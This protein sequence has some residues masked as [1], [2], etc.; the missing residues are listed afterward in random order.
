MAHHLVDSDLE[1]QQV[2]SVIPVLPIRNAVLF[3]MISMPLVVGRPRSILA[4]ESS[5]SS[6]QLL[7]IVAQKIITPGD[8]EPKDLYDIGTLCKLESSTDN[9]VGGRQIVV[10]GVARYR[11]LGYQRTESGFLTAR[12]EIVADITEP[13]STRGTALFE[14]LKSLSREIMDLLPGATEALSRLIDR[15]DDAAYMTHVVGAYLNLSLA[16]KQEILETVDINRRMEIL[17]ELMRKERD[18]LDIQKEIR[19]KMSERLNRAQREAL[20]REQLRTIRSELGEEGSEETSDEL[21]AK[22]RDAKLPEEAAKQAQEEL[23]RLRALPQ[24]SAEYHVIRSYLEWLAVLP[25]QKTSQDNLDLIRARQILDEDHY[26]LESVKRRI[27]Q[28]LSVA[29]LKNDLSGPILCLVGPPGVGKTSLGQSIART[30]GRKFIRT[31]LG[32]V[33]DEAE[34]RGHRRTYVGAMPGRIIQSIKRAGTKN[35]LMLLDEIDKLRTDFHGDPSAAMLEVLDP[36]QNKSFTD[37]Y[38]DIAF[39][40]SSVFFV[41]TANVVDTIPA[42]L[43]DRMETIEVNGYTNFEKLQIAKRY[44]VPKQL[45]EHGLRPEQIEL[46]EETL[47]AIITR[48]T[49]E[50]GVRELQR[51][52][53]ALFRATAESIVGALSVAPESGALPHGEPPIQLTPERLQDL[54]GS[55]KYFPELAEKSLHPGISTGLAWTPHGGDILFIETSEMP[56]KGQ[57]VLTG[58]LGDVMKESAHLALSLARSATSGFLHR[59]YDFANHDIH[60][61]VPAGAIPKDGP[62][63]G[64]TIVTA[65][66]SLLLKLPVS[67]RLGMTGEI[68]LRGVVLPVGG[69]KEKILAAHRAGLRAIILPRRNEQDLR[70]V[71]PEILRDLSIMLVDSVDEVLTHAFNLDAI[72]QSEATIAA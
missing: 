37:H 13:K 31:S 67:P 38:L 61:H 46:P 12:G 35:P 55:E 1:K 28:F 16:Q 69:I 8:P 42:P 19:D 22:I 18:V 71:P 25:W 39:D 70:E 66:A 26:G 54:L 10:T 4:L 60:I 64:V 2:P 43:R 34:V 33:R 50:A 21:E 29:Q 51:K 5:E 40:L 56:G 72:Q 3:P 62:S 41:A 53:A 47:M 24:A 20:L 27:L 14:N 65:L 36:E 32:G 7:I 44:L 59:G 45:K 15:I 23:K 11:V 6:H 48:Y 30:L 52:I 17:L 57:L 68:T 63:A 49:R 58:Q 9:E